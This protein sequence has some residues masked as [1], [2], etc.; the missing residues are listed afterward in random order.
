MILMHKRY[1]LFVYLRNINNIKQME[2]WPTVE[3]EIVFVN[4][5]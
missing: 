3:K 5:G 4:C 2:N 1:Q